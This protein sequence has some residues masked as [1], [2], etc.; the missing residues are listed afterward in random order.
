M[1]QKLIALSVAGIFMP[2]LALA[3]GTNVTIYGTF[4]VDFDRVERDGATASAAALNSLTVAPGFD[5]ENISSRNR[6]S[7]NSSS[8]GFRGTEDLGNGWRAIF[9]CESAVAVDGGGTGLCTRNTHVGLAGAWGAA[10]YGQWDTPYKVI[11]SRVDPWYFTTIGGTPTLIGTTGFGPASVTRAGRD[12]TSAD[13]QFDRRQ[14]NSVQYWTPDVKDSL[15]ASP[16]Q[17]TKTNRLTTRFPKSTRTFGQCLRFISMDLS[18]WLTPT[19]ATPIT[20]VYLACSRPST[21]AL[22]QPPRVASSSKDDGHKLIASYTFANTMIAGTY[23]RLDYRTSAAGGATGV[24]DYDRDAWYLVVTHQIGAGSIRAAYGRAEDGDCSRVVAE[25]GA[26]C[27]TSGLG[28]KH[29]TF[30]YRHTLS[31]RTDLY[32]LYSKVSNDSAGSYDFGVN[33]VGGTAIGA[34]SEGVA[35]GIKHSF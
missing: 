20:L 12:G 1:M 35:L 17:R 4:N 22:A 30:G 32:A 31:K 5:P 21:L 9:Q 2:G 29:Y 11:S 33:R 3:Q 14:G 27:S 13:A 8:L 34:D 10:F 7:S 16:I 19:S 6:V 26:T 25:V 18:T 23:E 28:A 15:A 24:T